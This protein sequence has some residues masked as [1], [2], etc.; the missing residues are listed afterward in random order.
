MIESVM[1]TGDTGRMILQDNT[2]RLI[3]EVVV[4]LQSTSP[5]AIPQLPWSFSLDAVQ[6]TIKSYPFGNTT[7]RQTL[8]VIHVGSAASF[9]FH[10]GNTHHPQLGGPTDFEID[11]TGGKSLVSIK[12]GTEYKKAVPYV[13]VGGVWKPAEAW[14]A[15]NG[16]WL[17]AL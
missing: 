1:E 9:T 4:I 6:S 8:G 14:A 15:H 2:D 5:V 17:K 10:L 13:R 11:L 16:S 3:K 7:V 12:V